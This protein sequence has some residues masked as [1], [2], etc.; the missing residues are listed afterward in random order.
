[1]SGVGYDLGDADTYRVGFNPLYF[2]ERF[3]GSRLDG[4]LVARR[5]GAGRGSTAAIRRFSIVSATGEHGGLRRQSRLF[6]ERLRTAGVPTT[7]VQVQRLEP[8]ADHPGA[9][10]RPTRPP[11]RRCWPSSTTHPVRATGGAAARRAI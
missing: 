4:S 8:R 3:G 2:A 10:P 9:E 6:E 1:M 7:F 11:G 5:L